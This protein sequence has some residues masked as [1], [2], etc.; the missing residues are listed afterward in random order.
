MYIESM[1]EQTVLTVAYRGRECRLELTLRLS[2]EPNTIPD[3]GA[4]LCAEILP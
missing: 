1:S 2:Q 3:L 4:H